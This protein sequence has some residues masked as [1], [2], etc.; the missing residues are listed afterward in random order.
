VAA[1]GWVGLFA[2]AAAAGSVTRD[3][4]T[5]LTSNTILVGGEIDKLLSILAV[6]VIIA[7]AIYRARR[8]MVRAVVEQTAARDLSRFFAPEV[9]AR[10]K[11]SEQ[12][13][14]AGSGEPR[15]AA[16][17][18]LDLRGFTRYAA[19][20]PP[21]AVMRLLSDYQAAMVPIIR[22]HGGRVDK[23]LGDGILATFGAVEPSSTYAADGLRA[24]DALMAEA[25]RWSA[26]CRREGR[27][28]PAV[29]GALATGRVLFGAVG[30]DTRL[31]YTV[32]GE[33][34][35]LSAKLEK[36]NKDLATRALC[37]AATYALGLAQ[38]YSS[39]AEQVPLPAAAVAGL[40]Q[41]LDL[42]RLAG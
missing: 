35:N 28:C 41:P 31:E 27:F 4:V 3:Y 7:V 16:I 1:A 29:N 18:S 21:E 34:V 10:I 22:A 9:A 32:I 37:D 19:G 38:G 6:T 13:I 39:T 23:F 2:Y 42:V 17:L 25:E 12:L 26:A 24:L 20:A 30:D 33:A 5:Y 40:P 36:A 15:D 11:A 8:L 14:R